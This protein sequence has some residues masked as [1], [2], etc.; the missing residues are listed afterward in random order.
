MTVWLCRA[1]KHGEYENKFIEENRIYCTWD[2]LP[3]SLHS[4]SERKDLFDYFTDQEEVK[5]KT[6]TNW[7]SQVWPFGFDMQVGDW[8]MLP[9]KVNPVINVGKITSDYRFQD[10]ATIPFKHFREVDWFKKSI[11]RKLF[12]QDILYSLGAFMTICRI[13][14]EERIKSIVLEGKI[15]D[16]H[17]PGKP[18]GEEDQPR[19]IELDAFDNIKDMLIRKFK[20]HGMAKVIASILRANGFTTFVSS[21]G[22]D[23]GVDILASQGA[24][25]F[26]GI[27]ICVQV[28]SSDTPVD[29]PTLDQL[30]GTMSNFKAEYGLLVS[31][32]GFKSSVI[33]ET[34]NQFFKVRLWTHKEVVE[35]FIANYENLD[36]EIKLETG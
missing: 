35:Q 11:P 36:D 22:P 5:D 23:K 4:F 15:I 18:E 20:G 17:P 24:L 8:V 12:D 27:N 13:K 9:S 25:G 10:E 30:I 3:V 28:K 34:A 26:G 14:Q 2:N 19:D 21:E 16:K 29:R 31:W 32:G 1:G 7:V 33:N 6:A